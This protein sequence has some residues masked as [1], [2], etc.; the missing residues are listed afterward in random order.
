MRA[1]ISGVTGQDGHYLAELLL[2]KG[3][4]VYGLVRRTSAPPKVPTGVKVIEGDVTDYT[5][6][7]QALRYALPGEVYNLAAQSFVGTSFAAPLATVQTN[8]VGAMNVFTAC[9]DELGDAVRVY[10]AGT[11][12]MFGG[13]SRAASDESTPFHPRSPYGC[14][15]VFAHHAAVNARERGLY[16]SNGILFNHESP[17]RGE[18]FV[19]RKVTRAVGRILAGTQK[20][21]SLGNLSAVRDWGFAGD[22]VEAMWRMLQHDTPDDFVIATGREITVQSFVEEAFAHAG[23]DWREFVVTAPEEN[24][25]TDVHYLSANPSKAATELGWRAKTGID[26]LIRMMVDSDI[27]LASREA[28]R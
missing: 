1:L 19:T 10:Q 2:S 11:S 14:A 27:E 24:R 23:L 26:D 25:P 6:L 7:V 18:H 20:S 17:R 22:Y 9:Y 21:L 12:E 13:V 8:G 3:Y 28:R 15:K 5:S 4:D 16:V